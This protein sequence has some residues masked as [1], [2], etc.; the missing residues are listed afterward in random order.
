MSVEPLQRRPESAGS[1]CAGCGA[2]PSTHSAVEQAFA[3]EAA[4]DRI[5]RPFGD[6][7]VGEGFEVL[8][9]GEAVARARTR[10][11][12]GSPG[13]GCRAEAV[14]ARCRAA[15]L[16]SQGFDA[17]ENE[18]GS[19]KCVLAFTKAGPQAKDGA[20]LRER[21]R[22]RHAAPSEAVLKVLRQQQPAPGIGRRGQN[23]GVASTDPMFDSQRQC[24]LSG[25]T[26]SFRSPKRNLAT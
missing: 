20:A 2:S 9:D 16:V 1:S 13:R 8:D 4:E 25:S 15:Y 23:D 11:S 19:A 14:P 3:R 5:D 10:P 17:P 22:D 26:R 18:K 12:A 24:V 21:I 6:D 7:E